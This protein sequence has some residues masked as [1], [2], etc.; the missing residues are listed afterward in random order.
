MM[1]FFCPRNVCGTFFWREGPA[2]SEGR[3]PPSMEHDEIAAYEHHPYRVCAIVSVI[4]PVNLPHPVWERLC[5][6]HLAGA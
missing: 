5:D 4:E 6:C 2:S 3:S 1:V